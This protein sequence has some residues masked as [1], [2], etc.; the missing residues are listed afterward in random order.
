[1]IEATCQRWITRKSVLHRTFGAQPE[2]M[3]GKASTKEKLVE[4]AREL[5]W[6]QGYHATGLK[7][8]LE[9]AGA[10]SGSLYHAFNSKEDLLLAVLDRYLELLQP[11][12]VQPAFETTADPIERIF[13]IL[14]GYRTL[15]LRTECTRGCPIGN[16]A[17]ELGDARPPVR[18]KIARNFANWCEAIE[19]CLKA[20]A[21]RLPGGLDRRALSRFV[22]T[23]MEGGIM[24]ARAHKNIEPFD[25][26]VAQLKDYFDRLLAEGRKHA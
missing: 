16:L 6:Q 10:Q 21:D 15:L 26:T 23:V 22:L 2:Q 5:F 7:Q 12:I 3:N 1:M 18:E 8:I 19:S 4:A 17:L 24:Q 14:D 20:A 9:A 25:G 13:A 11:V